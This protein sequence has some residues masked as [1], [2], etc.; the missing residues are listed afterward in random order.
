[1]T[2]EKDSKNKSEW[3][4][5]ITQTFG[6]SFPL[7]TTWN[8]IEAIRQVLNPFV[9]QNLN[10][11]L[12]PVGGCYIMATVS[13]SPEQGCLEFSHDLIFVQIFR[14][15][16]L[17][18]EHFPESPWNSF[19]LLELH[20]L[21]PC[22]VYDDNVA[23]REIVVEISPGVYRDRACFDS[24]IL[25]YDDA[26]KEIPLPNNARLVERHMKGKFFI[27][28]RLNYWVNPNYPAYDRHSQMTA[29]QMRFE[30]QQL[31]DRNLRIP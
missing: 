9:K 17:F 6:M 25:G 2:A 15:K 12:L 8:D 7:S 13:R 24:G 18:F 30:I 19:F 4:N 10:L 31:I 11:T 29:Q 14:P 28:S 23:M 3:T 1:M 21:P 5:A 27:S 20:D 22:G 16:T 26:D